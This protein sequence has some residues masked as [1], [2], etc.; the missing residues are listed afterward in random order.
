MEGALQVT[1]E[2]RGKIK[3]A[4]AGLKYTGIASQS[5]FLKKFFGEDW[6]KFVEYYREF[7]SIPQ[8]IQKWELAKTELML[9]SMR[10]QWAESGKVPDGFHQIQKNV[11][12]LTDKM[13]KQEEGIKIMG[14]IHHT[15]DDIRETVRKQKAMVVDAKV[16]EQRKADV[17]GS[18]IAKD[19]S[20]EE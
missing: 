2:E 5:K 14:E 13:R 20:V 18:S 4:L 11:I 6:K 19:T 15:H 16:I 8:S 3:S 1:K 7:G 9:E 10:E 12:A 17:A